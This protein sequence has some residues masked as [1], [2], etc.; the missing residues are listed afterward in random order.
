MKVSMPGPI[1]EINVTP[2]VDVCLV[3]VII[4]MVLAPLAMQAA[5]EVASS[6]TNT[7]KGQAAIN[8]NVRIDLSDKGALTINGQK[9][10]W[11]NLGPSV[12]AALKRSKDKL[13]SLNASPNVKVGQVVEILDVSR[14]N[15]ALRLALLNP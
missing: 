13:V 11:I 2:L 1:T 7:A 10:E 12:G 5:I 6:R 3:L 4:F 14:Q 8:E 9:V 15:G